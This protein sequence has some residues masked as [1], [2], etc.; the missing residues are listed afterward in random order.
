MILLK[1]SYLLLY[2]YINTLYYVIFN[3]KIV[4]STYV[5]FLILKSSKYNNAII[6]II[7]TKCI[8]YIFKFIL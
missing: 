5:L 3:C 7:I 2:T 8:L 6:F 1:S 4:Q